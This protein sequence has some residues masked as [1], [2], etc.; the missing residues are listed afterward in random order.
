MTTLAKNQI[1]NV[2]DTAK[3]NIYT[4]RIITA[5][6]ATPFFGQFIVI[7]LE[8]PVGPKMTKCFHVN[9]SCKP[10]GQPQPTAIVI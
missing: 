3:G 9:G 2:S 4:G 6:I 7:S 5:G 1:V 10:F 8:A